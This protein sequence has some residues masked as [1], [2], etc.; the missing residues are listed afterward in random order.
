MQGDLAF[1]RRDVRTLRPGEWLNDEVVNFWMGLLQ[2]REQPAGLPPKVHLCSSFFWAKFMEG[3]KPS[4][5]RVQ[6]WT[7]PERGLG[8]SLL[9]CELVFVPINWENNHW[10]S[11]CINLRSERLEYFDSLGGYGRHVLENL[12][13][14]IEQEAEARGQA[15]DTSNWQRVSAPCP[16]QNNWCAR[17]PDDTLI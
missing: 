17:L 12:A 8:Y 7:T 13:Y 10:V 4:F 15:L 16:Q 14:Y 6:R 5:R 2:A 3:G 9:D 11:C 1:K